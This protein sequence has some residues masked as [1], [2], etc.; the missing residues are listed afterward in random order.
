MMPGGRTSHIKPANMVRSRRS[1]QPGGEPYT[2]Y[3]LVDFGSAVNLG[4]SNSVQRVVA[5]TAGHQ[6]PEWCNDKLVGYKA[7]IWA[8]G[9]LLLEL[10]TGHALGDSL[11]QG[12][13]RQSSHASTLAAMRQSAAYSHLTEDEWGCVTA[14]LT[15]EHTA[16]PGAEERYLDDMQ[17]KTW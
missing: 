3:F 10:W 12:L 6:S 5:G 14:C 15:Y 13:M 9:V 16:R 11:E 4:V 8:V 17:S 1:T 2:H 7:D